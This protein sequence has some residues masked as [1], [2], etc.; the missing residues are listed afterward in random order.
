MLGISEETFWNSD[1]SFL[2]ALAE[3]IS[4][5]ESWKTYVREVILENGEK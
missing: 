1:I 4:A 2:R 3:N 5:Y